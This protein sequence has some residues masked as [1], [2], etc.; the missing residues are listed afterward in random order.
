MKT[1]VQTQENCSNWNFEI[2]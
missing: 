2:Q 1:A